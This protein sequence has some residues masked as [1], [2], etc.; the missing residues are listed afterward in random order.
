MKEIYDQCDLCGG[1]LSHGKT[2]LEIRRNR[3][4][5]IL[6]DIPADVCGQCWEFYLTADISQKVDHFLEEYRQHRP[7]RYIPV[8][9]FSAVHAMGLSV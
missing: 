6:N 8:P 7:E 1:E 2:S 4:L 9:E 3:E 5:I